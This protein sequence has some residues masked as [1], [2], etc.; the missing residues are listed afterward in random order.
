MNIRTLTLHA[1]LLLLLAGG[2]QSLVAADAGIGIFEMATDIGKTDLLGS[3]E[4]HQDHGVYRISGS[5]KNIWL[6]EDA[7]NFLWKK[8]AGDLVFGM[9]VAW[10][11]EG[12]EPHRKVCAMVRQTLDADSAY[13]D[14]AVHGDGLIELQ[15]RPEKGATTLAA[16][17]PV[18][19]PARVTVERAGDVF[20]VFASKNGGPFQIVGSVSLA[21]PDPVCVGLAVCAHNAANL[22]TA[23]VSQVVLKNVIPEPGAKR[24]RE[25]SLETLDVQT[26]ERRLVYREYSGMEAPNWSRDGKLFYLNGKVKGTIWTVPVDGGEPTL[27]NTGAVNRNNND[28]GLSFDGK[29]LALSSGQG[30]DGSKIY[31]VPATGGEPRLVTPTGPSY[32]HGWSPDGTTLAYCAKRNGNF[33]VY[34]IPVDGG[35]ERRLTAAEGLDDGCEY[36]ADGTK[37]YFH[38]ERAGG[39]PKIF[40]MNPDGTAQEQVTYDAE[41]ADWFPHPSPDG[42]WLLF[43]SFDQSVKGHPFD[44]NVV[45]RLMPISGGKPKVVARIFGGQG[46]I[47][48]PSWS[49]DSTRVAFVSY[50]YVLPPAGKVE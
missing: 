50:R 43:L 35:E 29:W 24:I 31:V 21:M 33:D 47:N 25:S 11:G 49:P 38:S 46:T 6:N 39:V 16:R 5:G 34:T 22:E 8:Y 27:L 44:Q 13:V 26:G 45:L 18:K 30:A 23:L 14:V 42:K 3:A 28:H 41:Y 17:T 19:A 40:R 2:R 48:V 4:F 1:V 7:G 37:I 15:Y 32:W 9:D 36:T 12:K 20:T 10:E